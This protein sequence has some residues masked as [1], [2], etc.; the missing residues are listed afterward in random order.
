MKIFR[1]IGNFLVDVLIIVIFII[2]LLTIVMSIS[3]RERNGVPSILGYAVMNVQ[4]DSMEPTIMTGDLIIAKLSD[5]DD[6]QVGDIVTYRMQVDKTYVLNTHRIAER[7]ENNGYPY[8]YTKGDNALGLDPTAL[9]AGDIV[10]VYSGIRIPL[11]GKALSFL[12]TQTGFFLCILLP[13]LFLFAFELFRFIRN[14]IDYNKQ[15]A[16]ETA[17]AR[18][19]ELTEE[20]KKKAIEE[21]LKQQQETAQ[22]AD[23]AESTEKGNV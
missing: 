19:A 22:N 17:E 4:T 15:K 5:Q 8:F 21:Y 9:A 1:K 13:L 11:A 7:H 14:V 12:K 23:N 18:S 6:Y 3:S 2:S 10:A 20:L 16:L